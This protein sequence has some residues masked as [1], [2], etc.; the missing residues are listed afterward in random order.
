PHAVPVALVAGFADALDALVAHQLADLRVQSG[1]VHLIGDL[2]HH[3][4]FAVAA[5][6]LLDLRS[7]AHHDAA[8]TGFVGLVD[9]GA[10]VDEP[11]GREV[12]P[13]DD[14]E[15]LLDRRVGL[16]DQLDHGVADLPQVVGRDVGRHP[17]R[18][19]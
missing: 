2:G 14:R 6:D 1:L 12:R 19:A 9:A 4:L 7:C 16:A 11:T 17:D 10:A 15:Q 13:R 3:D 18:D 8:A 5:G